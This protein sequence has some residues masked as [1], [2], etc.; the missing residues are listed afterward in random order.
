VFA[1]L[2]ILRRKRLVLGVRQRLP[3]LMRHRRPGQPLVRLASHILEA[4]FRVLALFVPIAVVGPDLATRYRGAREMHTMLVS[5]LPESDI[6]EDGYASYDSEL[7]VLSVGRLDPEKNPLLMADILA[8]LHRRDPRWRLEVCGDGTLA[9]ELADRLAALGVAQAAT[10]HGYVPVHAGLWDL[11]R[12]C[13]AL[14]H[15][16]LTEGVPQVLLEAFAARLPVVATAVGGVAAV[17][18]G[19]GWL[20]APDDAAS[21]AEALDELARA[22]ELRRQRVDRGTEIVKRHT[23]EAECEKLAAFLRGAGRGRL[24]WAGR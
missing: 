8:L 18:D 16:S 3:E 13:H 15:V 4:A 22:E 2:T 24:R 23:M 12:S 11:Y 10:L 1:L 21:A 20:I 19:G 9:P 17:V 6:V 14:L 7:R 5:L